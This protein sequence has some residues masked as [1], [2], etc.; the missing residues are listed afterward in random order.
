MKD[1]PV[2][3]HPKARFAIYIITGVG[4]LVVAYLSVKEIIGSAEVG[5]WTGLSAFVNG[6]AALNVKPEDK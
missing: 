6:L 3:K 4:S 1:L 5:L 2:I